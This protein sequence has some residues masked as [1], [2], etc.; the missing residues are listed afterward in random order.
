[1]EG[2]EKHPQYE[3]LM[4]S[5]EEDFGYYSPYY[6]KKKAAQVGAQILNTL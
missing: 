3:D 5:V 4:P 2:V 6:H 1:V